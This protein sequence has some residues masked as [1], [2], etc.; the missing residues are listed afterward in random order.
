MNPI[1]F[2]INGPLP[3][4]KYLLGRYRWSR[5]L[6]LASALLTCRPPSS[7]S[8]TLTLEVADVLTNISFTIPSGNQAEVIQSQTLNIVVPAN[9]WVRWKATFTDAPENAAA[10]ASIT[11]Q[12][13]ADNGNIQR[14]VLSVG[15]VNGSERL[16]LFSYD[17]LSHAF[18]PLSGAASR[19][20]ILNQGPNN[21]LTISIQDTSALQVSSGKLY[22]NEVQA[23]GATAIPVWPRLE[24][25]IDSQRIATLAKGGVLLVSQIADGPPATLSPADSDFYR[26]FEFYSVGQLTAVVTPTG[27]TALAI[28]QP[29]PA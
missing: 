6:R 2:E 25:Q 8:L 7:G 21:S 12:A 9:T 10:S 11:V 29:L 16:V 14:P 13:V 4:S 17:S 19:A 1:L 22:V 26:R 23:T 27:I 18:Y 24:F 5:S 28:E 15:W 3:N 20:N